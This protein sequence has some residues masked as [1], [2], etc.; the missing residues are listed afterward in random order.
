MAKCKFSI[1]QGSGGRY[2]RR[3][4]VSAT[5]AVVFTSEL[6][7]G[8]RIQTQMPICSEHLKDKIETLKAM[9]TPYYLVKL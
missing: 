7:E 1:K 4:D 3:C 6:D 5:E 2:T 9:Q 8:Y